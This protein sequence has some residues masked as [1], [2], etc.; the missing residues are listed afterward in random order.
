MTPRFVAVSLVAALAL[1]ALTLAQTPTTTMT[2]P[3][4]T[5]NQT[6]YAPIR[7]AVMAPDGGTVGRADAGISWTGTRLAMDGGVIR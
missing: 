7:A 4:P 5:T 3:T 1:A 6:T 2:P